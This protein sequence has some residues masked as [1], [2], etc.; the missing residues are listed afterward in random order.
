MLKIY[1]TKSSYAGEWNV[2]EKLD[3]LKAQVI[4]VGIE[5]GNE[6]NGGI[7]SF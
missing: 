2:D 3:S 4:V 6:K 5:H 7:D 1:L